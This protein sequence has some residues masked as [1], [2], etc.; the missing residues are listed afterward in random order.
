[1]ATVTKRVF[2]I[3]M[4]SLGIILLSPLLLFIGLLVK[5]D[6]PGPALFR[7]ERIGRHFR[8]FKI[9]KFRTMTG[10]PSGD[11][12]LTVGED[13]RI[14]RVGRWLRRSK[15]DELPQLFNV[16]VG[17][18]SLVGRRPE[19]PRYVEMFRKDYEELL[20]VQPGMTDAAS[21]TYRHEAALLGMADNAEQ[22][23]ISTILPEKIR[24]AKIYLRHS[25]FLVD[26]FIILRTLFVKPQRG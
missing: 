22:A 18:M 4:S 19:V 12:T 17:D 23:Y 5:I 1:M 10:E 16:V 20:A 8:P 14:T 13:V 21:I 24:I 6:S 26:L 7:Q 3:L 15:L 9:F 25:S 2:D 11:V